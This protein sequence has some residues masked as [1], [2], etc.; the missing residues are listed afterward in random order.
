MSEIFNDYDEMDAVAHMRK[1]EPEITA[2]YSDDE[3][4][5]FIDVMFE[6][7]EQFDEDD[8]YEFE[9]EE[10]V[11]FIVRQQKRDPECKIAKEHLAPLIEAELDYEASIDVFSD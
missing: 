7:F 3:L 1:V 4:V 11:D 9:T 8:D 10:V 6:F 5:L 2:N